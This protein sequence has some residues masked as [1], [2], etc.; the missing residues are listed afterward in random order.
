MP[1]W[2]ETERNIFEEER[3]FLEGLGFVLDQTR[4]E[5]ERRVVFNGPARADRARKL[6]ITFPS[7][8]PSIAPQI[9]DDGSLPLLARHHTAES[10]AFCLF[11][12]GARWWS[13]RLSIKDALDPL[14]IMNPGKLGFGP[15]K[16]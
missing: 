14:G 5:G 11:G 7:G 1:T 4:F 8:Y 9:A 3:K 10:R 6:T 13:S 15:P 2:F 12:H 16:G